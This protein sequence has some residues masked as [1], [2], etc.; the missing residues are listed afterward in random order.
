MDL[1]GFNME[2]FSDLLHEVQT[3]LF[4]DRGATL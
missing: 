1:L 4:P 2:A 3:V